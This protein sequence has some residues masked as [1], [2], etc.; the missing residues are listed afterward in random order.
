[1]RQLQQSLK[2]GRTELVE[3]PLPAHGP[4][5]L[6][7]R[8]CSSLISAGTERMLV[9]FGKAGLIG[10]ARQQPDKVRQVIDKARTDG[11]QSTLKTVRSKLNTS[12]PMGYSNVGIV[13]ALGEDVAGYS[14]GDRVVSNGPHAEMVVAP[15]NLVARIPENVSDE[16]ASFTVV[17]AIALQGVRLAG[18]TLGER[19]AVIGLGLIGLM[20]VQ[21]LRAQGCQVIGLD[22]DR[23]KLKLASSFGAEVV[24]LSGGGDGVD[25]VMQFSSGRG[26][27]AVLLTTAT[28]SSDPVRSAASMSRQRGR[29][30]LVGTAGLNFSRDDFYKKELSFQVSC[31]YGPG[32]YDPS[33][34]DKGQ[35]YPF[36]YVRWTE[37]RNFEA[38]L[39]LMAEGKIDVSNLIT[40]RFAFEDAV[41]A[42]GILGDDK[43]SKI[44]L[45]LEYPEKVNVMP[46]AKAVVFGPVREITEGKATV[47]FI[48]AGNYASG[49]LI[50]A[51]KS[52]GAVLA[53]VSSQRGL[54][55]TNTA[56][57]F[58]FAE[59]TTDPSAQISGPG[60]AIVI[61]TRHDSHA[62]L[63]SE[64]LRAGKHVFVEKPI[65][66]R[67]DELAEIEEILQTGKSRPVLMVGFNRRFSP[68]VQ[69]M[70]FLLG[71][72]DVPKSFVYTVNAGAV[73]ADHWTQDKDI[74]GGR[75]IGEACHFIDLLRFLADSPIAKL[76][77]STM[78]SESDD[79]A[80]ITLTFVD[81]SIG[82]V[83]YWA[84]GHR[85]VA[86]ERLEVFVGGKILQLD[87]FRKLRGYGWPGFS[88]KSSWSQDKGQSA[89]VE[90]F[91]ASIKGEAGDPIPLDQIIEVSRYS[92][93]ASHGSS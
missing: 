49:V 84:N 42:Y 58:G 83:H 39:Q 48:G 37:Q 19:V 35:D 80:T 55:A 70:K 17:G 54:S 31:S 14:T 85:S 26:V 87:N 47:S 61:T 12:I 71:G 6:R 67:L 29:I 50:P 33:Y 43:V 64:A 18:V 1:M 74:G 88:A 63:V 59:A 57:K 46:D 27:D 76:A 36:A 86:K 66:L 75:I 10:K 93:H 91:I 3:I 92:I 25:E 20:T 69:Q 79:V 56:R 73:P 53:S 23:E 44:G 13:D 90:A 38:V 9:N 5:E 45:L 89:C 65:C 72:A 28:D 22:F 8:T 40:H 2:T 16:T 51:F 15:A 52:A 78:A 30:V 11:V 81:G 32:R 68:L 7:I 34:E 82:T 62:K 21:L 41:N 24:D 4:G 60:D 77:S